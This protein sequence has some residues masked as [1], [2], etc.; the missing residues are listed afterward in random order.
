[1]QE[2]TELS[3]DPKNHEAATSGGQDYLCPIDRHRD[4]HIH[5]QEC[6]Y[7]ALMSTD[8]SGDFNLPEEKECVVEHLVCTKP[9]HSW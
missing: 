9:L 6:K 2:N 7:Y 8:E 3:T 1:M 4:T 5:F